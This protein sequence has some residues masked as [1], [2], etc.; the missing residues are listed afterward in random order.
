MVGDRYNVQ[1]ML[2]Y[3]AVLA[4]VKWI[5]QRRLSHGCQSNKDFFNVERCLNVLRAINM[6]AIKR[7]YLDSLDAMQQLIAS[8]VASNDTVIKEQGYKLQRMMYS[9]N[10]LLYLEDSEVENL[11]ESKDDV[12][13]KTLQIF[14][15][16]QE[17]IQRRANSS[18]FQKRY[19]DWVSLRKS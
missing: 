18:W 5:H 9:A 10:E 7:Q 8:A 6:S 1:H 19:Q 11:E 3:G 14:G 12:F 16:T 4:C 17:I 13:E 2:D 15:F